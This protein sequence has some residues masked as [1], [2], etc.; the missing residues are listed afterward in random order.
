MQHETRVHDLNDGGT[1][2]ATVDAVRVM[3]HEPDGLTSGLPGGPLSD[4]E[5]DQLLEGM[6]D[7]GDRGSEQENAP[8][9]VG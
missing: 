4:A 7:C 2:Y 1:D 8:S 9:L 5:V 6:T 3:A